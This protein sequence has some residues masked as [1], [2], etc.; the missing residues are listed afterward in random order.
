MIAFVEQGLAELEKG[1][2][3]FS[4]LF[5]FS[6]WNLFPKEFQKFSETYSE[7]KQKQKQKQKTT[8]TTTK[9]NSTL[10][11]KDKKKSL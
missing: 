9:K 5:C 10:Q 7:E 1:G 6:L 8:T 2:Y 11:R 3:N 4:V